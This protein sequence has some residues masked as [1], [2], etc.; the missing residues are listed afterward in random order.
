MRVNS[1]DQPTEKGGRKLLTLAPP[2]HDVAVKGATTS[3]RAAS[4]A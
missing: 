1:A 3:P 4:T 2:R